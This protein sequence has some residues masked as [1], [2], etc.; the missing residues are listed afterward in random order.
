MDDA[1]YYGEILVWKLKSP[2]NFT[3]EVIWASKNSFHDFVVKPH[4]I[5]PVPVVLTG[6][7]LKTELQFK[8][9]G[10]LKFRCKIEQTA[11]KVGDNCNGANR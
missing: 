3:P 9:Y 5:Q 8:I 1:S 7:S 10:R 2:K 4:H 11:M 6:I